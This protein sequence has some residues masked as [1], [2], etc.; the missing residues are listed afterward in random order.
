M[1][2]DIIVIGIIIILVIIFLPNDE[3]NYRI[4]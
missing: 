3:D 2:K 1:I 4:D